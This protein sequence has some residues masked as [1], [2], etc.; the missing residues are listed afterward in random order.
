MKWR[1]FKR[2][3]PG[4]YPDIDCPILVLLNDV[5]VVTCRWNDKLKYFYND[6]YEFTNG[7]FYA[8]LSYIPYTYKIHHP[9]GC[10]YKDGSSCPHGFDDDGYCLCGGRKCEH[11]FILNEYEVTMKRIWKEI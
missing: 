9:V 4:T 7:C 5:T 11:Q 3:D 8:Y 6:E 2:D 1:V 10:G